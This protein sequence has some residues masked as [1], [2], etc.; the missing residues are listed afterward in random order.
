[1]KIP[2]QSGQGSG[3]GGHCFVLKNEAKR[4]HTR[5]ALEPKAVCLAKLRDL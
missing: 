2:R 3:Y 1:M 5:W 4:S